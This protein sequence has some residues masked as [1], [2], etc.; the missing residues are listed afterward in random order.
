MCVWVNLLKVQADS[1]HVFGLELS[2][3][4]IYLAACLVS[5]ILSI[6]QTALLKTLHYCK[7]CI[8]QEL[9]IEASEMP[10]V[11]ENP[12]ILA[13]VKTRLWKSDLEQ[14]LSPSLC[15]TWSLLLQRAEENLL[16]GA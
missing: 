7:H 3:E 6:P 16:I 12:L 9:K 10:W 4:C 14:L 8:T 13:G 2:T 11:V 5:A 1:Q 15:I